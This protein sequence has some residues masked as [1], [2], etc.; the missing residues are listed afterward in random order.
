MV[1]DDKKVFFQY[2][3]DGALWYETECGFR[4]FVPTS[5]IGNADFHA[6]ERAIMLMRYIRKM[7]DLIEEAKNS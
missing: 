2:Y 5:D 4:F 7:M 1:K 6:E 3:R